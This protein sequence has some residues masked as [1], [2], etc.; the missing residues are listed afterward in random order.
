MATEAGHGVHGEERAVRMHRLGEPLERLMCAS[1]G[2]GVDDAHK[3]HVRM[4][5]ERGGELIERDDVAPRGLHRVDGRAA[6]FHHVFH[7]R[8][9]DA[10]HAHDDFVARLDEIGGDTFHPRHAGA[11]DGKSQRV[12]RLENFA[13]PRARLIHDREILRI[14]MPERGRGEGAQHALRNGA[15]AGAKEDAFGGKSSGD[16]VGHVGRG[17]K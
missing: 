3:L 16:G 12:F 17:K 1:A 4:R 9:K 10:V 15:G 5:G 8:A 14:Q 11:A 2:L 13:Q 7:A 6:A